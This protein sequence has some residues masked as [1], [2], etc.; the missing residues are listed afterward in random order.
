MFGLR[1]LRRM[2]KMRY[3]ALIA[4]D[5]TVPQIL[6]CAARYEKAASATQ[7]EVTTPVD[8]VNVI[9]IAV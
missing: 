8:D 1:G 7:I 6:H 3:T 9:A 5:K 4:P 2:P